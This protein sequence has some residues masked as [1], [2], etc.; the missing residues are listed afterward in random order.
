[1]RPFVALKSGAP[2]ADSLHIGRASDPHTM[3]QP[4]DTPV[5][6]EGAR[7][8]RFAS[9]PALHD[10]RF[11]VSLFAGLIALQ[12]I[13]Y[14]VLGTGR[15]GRGLSELILCFHN[16]LA[17]ACGWIAFRRARDASAV[18]W[19][20]FIVNLLF[21]MV[22]T[23]LMTASTILNI[24]LV[25]P[26]TWRVLFCLYGA[27]IAM[28]LFLPST[29][30]RGRQRSQIF[31]DQFQVAIVVGLGYTTFF[32]LPLQ[33]MVT[34]DALVRNLTISNL[35]SLFLLIGVFLRL[36]FARTPRSRSILRRLGIFLLSCATVTFIGNWIDLHNYV[37]ASA[38]FDL[39]WAVPYLVAGLVAQTW[40]P[41]PEPQSISEP[42]TFLSLLGSNIALVAVL[43]C[44]NLMLDEWKR[45]HGAMLTDGAVAALLL[46][47]TFRLALTQYAKQQEIFQRKAAQEELSIAN[48]TISGL[49]EEARIETSSITQINE[50]G[51]LLQACKSRDEAF[52]IIPE[53]M[54]RLFPATNGSLSL[55]N[56]SRNRA[57]SVAAW[58][59]HP[60]DHLPFASATYG[61]T[62]SDAA[63]NVIRESSLGSDKLRTDT[64]PVSIPLVANGEAIGVLSIQDD[65]RLPGAAP[66]SDPEELSRRQE[67]AYTIAEHIALTVSN[68]DMRAA[69]EVQATR[70]PLTGLYNRRYMQEFLEREIHRAR[71]RSRPL[72]LMLLDVD[73]FKRYN[74]TFGHA[75]GDEA[76][77]FVAETL[78]FNVR[79]EDL[80][81]RYGGEEFVVILP[82][83]SLQ[84]AA[85]RAEE[86]RTRLKELY[87]ARPGELPGP[88]TASIG[89]A[90]FPVTTDQVDLLIKC[91]DEALYQAKHEGRDRVVVARSQNIELGQALLAEADTN[92]A[93]M[94]PESE[95]FKHS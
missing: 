93:D 61:V 41:E 71:R 28:M 35:L 51:T 65:T 16:L 62:M 78:L 39:G 27:P 34:W 12:A 72:S 37:S 69:L 52:R 7:L 29:D 60:P 54:V 32:Y 57:E 74:D 26:S 48:Q 47:F 86:I 94:A 45:A 14:L 33:R 59:C 46:A 75:S 95:S 64:K 84:Q 17:I 11:V 38:W 10:S 22:P 68:L 89:V 9:L 25:P 30:Y 81:V 88:V 40:D 31:L 73:H 80:A 66:Y 1:M 19:F 36:Q 6:V 5:P 44:M 85:L 53:R 49:L 82:E 2:A 70:D 23:V 92:S 8:P 63:A 13:G 90:A 55:L 18:F 3:G 58:G 67:L 20:L 43:F 91:A 42:T 4:M 21:L 77:R 24:T 79:A 76:L 50:L 15:S 87:V 56:A 83:C